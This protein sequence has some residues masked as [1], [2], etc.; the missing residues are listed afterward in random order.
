MKKFRVKFFEDG[1]LKMLTFLP[2][3]VLV[4]TSCKSRHKSL[5]IHPKL[6]FNELDTFVTSMGNTQINKMDYYLIKDFSKDK[7]RMKPVLDSFVN[8]HPEFKSPG[9]GNYVVSF[10][11]DD[12]NLNEGI[13]KQEK[14]EY[15]YKLFTFYKDKNFLVDY[16]FRDMKLSYIDWSSEYYK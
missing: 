6:V 14:S 13:I 12:D 2:I 7:M 15:R 10:Y 4:G 11:L 1:V 16:T 5:V 9:F 3:L 8:T